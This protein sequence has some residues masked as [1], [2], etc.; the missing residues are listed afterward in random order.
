MNRDF[1][2]LVKAA[3]LI[4]FIVMVCLLFTTM[5]LSIPYQR[6]GGINELGDFLSGAF[7]PLAFGYFYL[8][9]KAQINEMKATV[10]QMIK[11]NIMQKNE[12]LYPYIYS[13]LNSIYSSMSSCAES[14]FGSSDINYVLKNIDNFDKF[15]DS[16]EVIKNIIG[17]CDAIIARQVHL[18][19]LNIASQRSKHEDVKFRNMIIQIQLSNDIDDCKRKIYTNFQDKKDFLLSSWKFIQGIKFFCDRYEIERDKFDLELDDLHAEK[20][21]N[22]FSIAYDQIKSLKVY[23]QKYQ[24]EYFKEIEIKIDSQFDECKKCIVEVFEKLMSEFQ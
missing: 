15:I 5:V 24:H 4:Y 12:K 14:V 6:P 16:S 23:Y 19:E 9:Y 21:R 11:Q 13:E 17:S 7:S 8:S 1:D 20:I 10:G 3:C 18:S 2:S 22:D